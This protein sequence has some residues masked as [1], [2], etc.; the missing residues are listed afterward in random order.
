[1]LVNIDIIDN[2][3]SVLMKIYENKK[4]VYHNKIYSELVLNELME[5]LEQRNFPIES[6][7]LYCPVSKYFSSYAQGMTPDLT[8]IDP[9]TMQPLAF[10]R[11][12]DSPNDFEKD[13]LFDEAYHLNKHTKKWL[14][15][16]YYIVINVGDDL[17]FYDL[18]TLISH[19]KKLNPKFA[20][21]EPMKYKILRANEYHKMAH[22]QLIDKNKLQ[23]F[24]KIAFSIIVPLMAVAL[25]VL[26]GLDIFVISELRLVVYGII[27]VSILI[28]YLTQVT[29]KD[30]SV[31][32]RDKNKINK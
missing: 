5:F 22:N 25:L 18:R 19:G 26:D 4:T 16:P 27:V 29:I 8:V 14:E 15:R 17:Q 2:I 21:S 1:M 11:T 12:Y 30:F 31:T 24:G 3:V 13:M 23:R 7:D 32:F 28:P 6:F 20:T 9:E 10:F